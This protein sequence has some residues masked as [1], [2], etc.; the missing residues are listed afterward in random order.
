MPASPLAIQENLHFLLNEVETHCHLVDLFFKTHSIELLPRIRARRG[1]VLTLREKIEAECV[2]MLDRRKPGTAYYMRVEA[3]RSLATA[4]EDVSANFLDC[5][6]EGTLKEAY[7]HPRSRA[8]CRLVRRIARSLNLIKLGMDKAQRRTGIKL[9][10]RRNGLLALYEEI[11]TATLAAKESLSDTQL[12]AA[13]LSNFGLKRVIDQLAIVG[14]ALLKADLGQV[15]SLQNYDHLRNTTA[16]LNYSLSDL[17]VRR[18][19]LTRSG[20]SIAAISHKNESDQ[21]VLAVYKEGDENKLDEEIQGVNNWQKV[22]PKLAPDVLAHAV[23]EGGSAAL[24]IEHLSGKTLEALLL[25]G[26]KE[27]VDQALARLFKTLTRIWKATYTPEPSYAKFMAQLDKRIEDSIKI[28]PDFF[29]EGYSICDQVRPSFRMLIGRVETKESRWTAPFSVLIHGDFNLDNLI[30]DV[31]VDRIYFID[32]H[33]STYL[34]YI[35]DIS[36]LMVSIYRLQVLSGSTRELMMASAIEI[37]RFARRFAKRHGDHYFEPRLAAGLARSFATSTRFIFDT[38]LASRM[39][40]RARY[41]LERL[42]Q[43]TPEQ[44]LLFKIPLEELYIE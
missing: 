36:V 20:S 23:S 32:L 42:A 18:L 4:L 3:I 13:I 25:E 12:R 19:A 39:H 22:D 29:T 37:Y 26:R 38:K 9:G 31:V 7:I 34:D 41:L 2:A 33:R 15:V 1:Y 44:E 14:E 40:L 30:Y 6:Q 28:H 24:L 35:Q 17:K 11:Q 10:R 8:C 43:L 27:P 5:V 21:A 16:T